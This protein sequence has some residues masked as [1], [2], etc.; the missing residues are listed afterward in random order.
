MSQMKICLSQVLQNKR[1]VAS[2][3]GRV[4]LGG[5]IDHRII[6]L[7]CNSEKLK[8]FNIAV[9]LYTK[10]ILKSYRPGFILI[11]SDKIG[12][13]EYKSNYPQFNDK[14]S[15]VSAIANF[16]NVDGVEI[17]IQ[18]EFPPMSGL[19]GSGS[20]SIALIVAFIKALNLEKKYNQKDIVWLAHS[21]EDSLFKNTGLQDQAAACFGGINL[22]NW[23]YSNHL[24]IFK[25]NPLNYSKI[26]F[27]KTSLIVYSGCPHYL[28]QKGSRII[29]SFF[30]QPECLTFVK[31]VNQNTNK[32]IKMLNLG[33]IDGLKICLNREEQL[34]HQFLKYRIPA[35]SSK[36]ISIARKNNCGVKF[37]G[38][39]GGGCLWLLGN[40]TEINLV[41]QKISQLESAKILPFSID[42]VG[43]KSNFILSDNYKNPLQ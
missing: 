27:E 25:V 5:G 1:V 42:Y 11:N 34:R 29:H 37:V 33:N 18:T 30:N 9:K 39:G 8:T 38:G 16:F 23:Q 13:K 7:I 43:V 21:I 12:S 32:F 20:L 41:K 19:G 35:A 26:D 14:Y 17:S 4:D 40:P 22:F 36:I 3:P 24:K 6:S 10:V 15:L 28:T 31:Q 2:A